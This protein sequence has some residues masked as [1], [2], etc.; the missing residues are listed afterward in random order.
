[1][2]PIKQYHKDSLNRFLKNNSFKHKK[3][4]VVGCSTG[5]DCHLIEQLGASEVVG[6]DLDDRIGRD[7]TSDKI[8]YHKE[9]ATNINSSEDSTFD[10]VYSL[11]TFE[12][13]FDI[14][15]AYKEILR[16]T[17]PKGVIYVVAS[18]LWQSPYGNHYGDLLK[19]WPWI[20]L[21]EGQDE[22]CKILHDEEVFNYGDYKVEEIMK[23]LFEPKHFNHYPGSYYVNTCQ[24]LTNCKII[25][26][27]L[28]LRDINPQN[29]RYGKACL[30]YGYSEKDLKAVSHLFHAIKE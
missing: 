6:I 4:L 21:I 7:Y 22:I 30:D 15:A 16:V 23:Y 10:V 25:S 19:D 18:P 26:N 8:S 28:T 20:H 1:M 27:T 24:S 5:V 12:Y 3:V 11:A 29:T 13:I 9:S 14:E 2:K 17:K